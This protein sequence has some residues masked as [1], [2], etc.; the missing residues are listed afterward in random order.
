MCMPDG[1]LPL[2]AVI[3]EYAAR[4]LVGAIILLRSRGTPTVRLAW[5]VVVFA[6]PVVGVVAYLLVGEVR[7]GRR[8]GRRH[9]RI[10][11]RIGGRT[12]VHFARPVLATQRNFIHGVR[13]YFS[14]RS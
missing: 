3:A 2:A 1:A 10:A 13:R 8:R 7:F 6:I 11:E 5:L 4:V 9:R 14:D 12:A